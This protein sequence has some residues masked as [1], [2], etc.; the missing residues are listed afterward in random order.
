MNWENTNQWKKIIDDI[1]NTNSIVNK[2]MVFVTQ[3][4]QLGKNILPAKGS[5]FNAYKLCNYSE[6]KVV[7]LGQD[8]YPDPQHPHGLAFSSLSDERPA[9]LQNIFTEIYTSMEYTVP[10]EQVFQTND[11]SCWAKQGVLL[12][13]A[14][15]TVEAGLPLSHKGKGWETFTEIIMH[16][17]N[18]HPNNL[19]FLLWGNN[20]R[21]MKK[22]I[23]DPRHVIL[24]AV[25]PSP[26]SAA[27][28]F[29]GCNHFLKAHW[30]SHKNFVD[31]RNCLNPESFYKQY[32]DVMRKNGV[33]PKNEESTI[34]NNEFLN[35]VIGIF[36]PE[37]PYES[38]NW[39]TYKI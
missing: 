17:L 5:I 20:A 14:I 21:E 25:H 30:F 26:L 2:L 15:L 29:F 37:L 22:Y 13:N 6:T 23:T 12:I 39:K 19:I 24:E 31:L 8:P 10:K 18:N 3:E 1:I 16:E 4:R 35:S 7:I 33:E 38:I 36:I 28:G 34:L 27:K 9:S 32:F 11:L